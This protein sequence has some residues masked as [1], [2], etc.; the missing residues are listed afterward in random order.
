[1]STLSITFL[2]L[3][4]VCVGLEA[5]FTMMEMAIVSVNK[6]RLYYYASRRNPKA[7]WI[8]YLLQKPSRLFGTTLLCVTIVEQ[9]GSECSRMFYSSLSVNPDFAPISQVII[10]LIFGELAP[11]FAARRHSEAV[12]YGGVPLLYGLSK[13]LYPLTYLID[14]FTHKLNRL[15]GKEIEEGFFLSREELQKAFEEQGDKKLSEKEKVN[16]ALSHI[17]SLKQKKLKD[18]MIP[19]QNVASS[20]SKALVRE[21]DASLTKHF[22]SFIPLYHQNPQN[23]VT[24]IYPADILGKNPLDRASNHGVSP[25][26][27]LEDL[28]LVLVLNQFRFNKQSVAVLMN[29]AGKTIGFITF[30]LLLEEIFGSSSG[31]YLPQEEL[32]HVD[33]VISYEMTIQEFNEHFSAH[34][35]YPPTQTL[36]ELL[37]HELKHEPAEG[38]TVY[39]YPYEFIVLEKEGMNKGQIRVRTTI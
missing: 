25:W 18:I 2:I 12:S 19:L 30:D 37:T 4:L 15:F 9:V 39:L 22:S 17:F 21:I 8:R 10:V 13:I 31:L 29:Q 1:M 35:S 11:L 36:E 33:Q 6:I 38:D 23:I 3:T 32:V 34:L 24:I 26:F 7:E 20:S 27:I 5:Y 14:Q 16:E 28:P